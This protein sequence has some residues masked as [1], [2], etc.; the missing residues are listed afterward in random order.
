MAI[1]T[2]F[3]GIWDFNSNYPL[4]GDKRKEGDDHIRGVKKGIKQTFPN[5]NSPLLVADE[6]LNRL[7]DLAVDADLINL[8]EGATGNIQNQ[9]DASNIVKTDKTNIFSVQ[10]TIRRNQGVFGALV[11]DDIYQATPG[12]PIGVGNPYFGFFANGVG[13]RGVI[14]QNINSNALPNG[15]FQIYRTDNNN[16]PASQLVL[17]ENGRV[18]IKNLSSGAYI[19]FDAD[20]NVDF[21]GVDN[22]RLNGVPVVTE[23]TQECRSADFIDS[24]S[25]GHQLAAGNKQNI[26]IDTGFG[27]ANFF[28]NFIGIYSANTSNFII[29]A[30]DSSG[31]AQTF[32]SGKGIND[33]SGLIVPSTPSAGKIRFNVF[34]DFSNAIFNFRIAARKAL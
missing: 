8:L 10:Q 17:Y 20:G 13:N 33:E 25:T 14:F 16:T 12:G 27:A 15:Y 11:I 3:D 9:L 31:Y 4:A 32:K 21:G 19:F 29:C 26:D 2:D 18:L 34:S 7:V 30:R 28:W 1:E 24:T 6:Q 5:I 23:N 22:F